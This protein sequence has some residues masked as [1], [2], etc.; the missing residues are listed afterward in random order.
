MRINQCIWSKTNQKSKR[1]PPNKTKEKQE[2][3]KNK[4]WILLHCQNNLLLTK[5]ACQHFLSMSQEEKGCS[6]FGWLP[7][8]AEGG[9]QEFSPHPLSS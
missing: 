8:G 1:K 3:H 9:K 7:R 2:A 5:Q 4:N 6:Q